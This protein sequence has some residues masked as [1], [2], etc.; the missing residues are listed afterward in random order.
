MLTWQGVKGQGVARSQPFCPH[1]FRVGEPLME[2]LGCDPGPDHFRLGADGASRS[3]IWDPQLEAPSDCGRR[4]CFAALL[5]HLV[6]SHWPGAN[7][8]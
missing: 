2:A 6:R 5:L 8:A 1:S 3:C 7:P 4:T